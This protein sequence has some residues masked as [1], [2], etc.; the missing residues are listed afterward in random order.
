MSSH[1]MGKWFIYVVELI[2][3]VDIVRVG[4]A[5]C[6][7]KLAIRSTSVWNQVVSFKKCHANSLIMVEQ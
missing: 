3:N 5:S 1:P 6:A 7:V 2:V 4:H